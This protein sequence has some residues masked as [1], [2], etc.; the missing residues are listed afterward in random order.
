ME[1]PDRLVL[2]LFET[3]IFGGPCDWQLYRYCTWE[4]AEQ[5]HAEIVE[6]CRMRDAGLKD[7]PLLL[8]ARELARLTVKRASRRRSP[9]LLSDLSRSYGW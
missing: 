3:V 6:C 8:K 7:Q 4:R 1:G 9:R 2:F 5:G